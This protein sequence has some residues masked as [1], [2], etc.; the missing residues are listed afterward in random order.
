V[1]DLGLGG[2][3]DEHEHPPRDLQLRRRRQARQRPEVDRRGQSG[4]DDSERADADRPVVARAEL[5]HPAQPQDA[6]DQELPL[7]ELPDQELPD[8]ELPLQELPDQELPDQELPLQEL[9]DQELPDQELPDQELPLHELPDQELPDH[10][11]PFQV[12]PDQEL[13]FAWAAA[14]AAAYH[15]IPKMSRSPVSIT[16][17]WVRWSW[18]RASSREP[19]PVEFLNF[20]PG[21]FHWGVFLSSGPSWSTPAP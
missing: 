11:L 14:I 7:H 19:R 8:Q 16:P 6:E 17:S 15:G 13:P 12:P 20:C 1:H 18:P 9:P 21:W 5:A 10:E 4:D 3:E 2:E